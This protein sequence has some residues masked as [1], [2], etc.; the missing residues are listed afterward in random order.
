VVSEAVVIRLASF[1]LAEACAFAATVVFYPALSA[2]RWTRTMSLLVLSGVILLSPLLVPN[3]ARF[4]RCL[5]AV[6]A[7]TLMLKL[8]DLHLGAARGHRPSFGS[9]LAF[10]PNIFCLVHRKLDAEPRRTRG[11][12]VRRLALFTPVLLAMAALFA[13][14]FRIEWLRFDFAA[15]HTVKTVAFFLALVPLTIVL[16]AAWSLLGGRGRD[17][18][19]NPFAARTPA[20]FWR[21]Y[22]RPVHQFLQEDVFLP[23]GGRRAPLRA[24]VLVFVVSAVVHEYVFS[25]PIGRVRGYQT[26]FFL[27][28]G[29]AV[30]ATMRFKPRGLGATVSVVATFAFNVATGVLFFASVNELLPF[31]RNDV[32]LWD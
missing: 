10:L 6:L 3:D 16:G 28:Q 7:V 14:W 29:L 15:E 31:Y 24:V 21:R 9:F 11:Q 5:A 27:L 26:T 18:M 13:A 12:N 4:L 20:D 19:D 1:G 22:N 23:A 25:V 30:A 8:Y 32:P 17:F 2:D